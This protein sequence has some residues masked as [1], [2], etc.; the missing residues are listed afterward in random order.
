M[1]SRF[2]TFELIVSNKLIII[3]VI[4]SG[5][6]NSTVSILF[7]ESKI[8]DSMLALMSETLGYGK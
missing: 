5:K 4:P 2:T 3:K 8:S 7:S 6:K 1:T